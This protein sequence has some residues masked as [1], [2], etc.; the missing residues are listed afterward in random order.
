MRG[1]GL[2]FFRSL[3]RGAIVR[4]RRA[5]AIVALV[6]L[7]SA[8]GL[9][10]L[11]LRTDGHALLSESA[12]EVVYD[13][14]IREQFGIEDDIVTVVSSHD[15]NGIFNRATLEL[16]RDLTAEFQRLP[17]INPSNVISLATEPGLRFNHD[18]GVNLGLIAPALTNQDGLAQLRED[19]KG[20]EIYTGTLVSMDGK[21]A[22]ILI[23][24]PSDADCGRVYQ[25]ILEIIARHRGGPDEIDVTGAPVAESLLGIQILEDLGVPQSWLGAGA[26]SVKGERSGGWLQFPLRAARRAGLVP[27]AALVM[28]LTLLACFRNVVAAL[29]P[30]P[31]VAAA[32]LFVFGWMGW[33]GTPVYLTMAVMP[34]LLTVLSVTNDIY[35]FNRYFA[36]IRARP[37][38][39]RDE[40]L[41]ET[42]DSL[43]WPV[44]CTALTAAAGFLSF[45]F[46]PLAPVRA[47]G[48]FTGLGALFGLFFSLTAVPA[49]LTLIPPAWLLT[50]WG[51]G[52]TAAVSRLAAGFARLGGWAA[53]WRWW[54][55]ATALAVTIVTPLGVRRLVVQD[56]WTDG[57]DPDSEFSRVTRLVNEKFFGMHLLFVSFDVPKSLT[58]MVTPDGLTPGTIVLSAGALDDTMMIRGSA[59]TL[60]VADPS[61]AARA[62]WR[63]KIEAVG[64]F[65]DRRIFARI[66]LT[67][68]PAGFW[69]AFSRAG[70]ARYEIPVHSHFKPEIIRSVGEL[71]TFIRERSNYAVGGTL[72]P[73][74]YLTTSRYITRPTDRWARRLENNS[75]AIRMLWEYYTMAVGPQRLREVVDTNY[76]RSLTTVFLKDANFVDTARL[77]S[78]IRDYERE[79]LAPKGIKLGFAGD[80]A[81]SQS[82]IAGIVSTQLRSLAWSLAG[83]FVV[84]AIMGGSARWGFYCLLPSAWAVLIKFAVMGWMGIPLGVATSMFAAM[85]LGLGVNCAI[86]LLEG[87]EQARTAGAAPGEALSRALAS[88]GP[89]A[90]I[91]TLAISLGFGTLMVSHVPANARLGLLLALGLASCFVASLLILP[92]LLRRG[93]PKNLGTAHPASDA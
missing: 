76:W 35:L 52:E 9:R 87:V 44:A 42:F 46:S 15:P 70:Q 34:V 41:G 90:F 65:R 64:R 93:L 5:L 57:F 13:K 72:G 56:S 78:D 31:G 53:R 59:I 10:W 49:L 79:H 25:G 22:V 71:E 27:T 24:I 43:V 23:G 58:G 51:A 19:L 28:M 80:V 85:T 6:T 69:E 3:A 75:T 36:L 54:V 20:L 89:P 30:L 48:V 77:M 73:W 83:I 39:G 66:G 1:L 8:P 84:T 21:C 26:R 2:R 40:L 63:S 61:G 45:S 50:R 11:R 88:T 37:G 7:V 82:L 55:V 47:F 62:V 67:D 17:G 14:S 18:T 60:S 81:V 33:S 38:A 32:L 12:P 4:P 68:A 16:T 91:N 74:D 86:H 29:L 92:V